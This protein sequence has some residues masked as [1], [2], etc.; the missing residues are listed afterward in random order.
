MA[1]GFRH[2]ILHGLDGNMKL[3]RDLFIGEPMKSFE[4]NNL[5]SNRRKPLNGSIYLIGTL[6]KDIIPRLCLHRHMTTGFRSQLLL[7]RLLFQM[8]DE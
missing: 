6:Q 4:N 8:I 2:M 5:L 7:R 1:K 3:L